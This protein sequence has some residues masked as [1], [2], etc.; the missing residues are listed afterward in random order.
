MHLYAFH[1]CT[2]ATS[3]I[4]KVDGTTHMD[5]KPGQRQWRRK[6]THVKCGSGEEC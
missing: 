4:T 3:K 1:F 2:F 6:L 5:V